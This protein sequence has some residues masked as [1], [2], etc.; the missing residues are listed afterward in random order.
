MNKSKDTSELRLVV[1]DDVEPP[2]PT[3]DDGLPQQP[4]S[5]GPAMSRRAKRIVWTF[6][7][8]II[9]I[10]AVV[11]LIGAVTS[12]P[13]SAIPTGHILYLDADQPS[14]RT[15]MLRGLYDVGN[16]GR[17]ELLLHENEPQDVDAG[18]REWIS[19]PSASPDGRH[20]AFVKQLITILDERQS[21]DY[22]IWVADVSP[23]H[24]NGGRMLIDLTPVKFSAPTRL[25][26]TSDST[27][28][29]FLDGDMLRT[30]PIRPQP[31]AEPA[32][33]I[34]EIALTSTQTLV[35]EGG[36][37]NTR[38]ISNSA[39]VA[40]R[41]NGQND[42]ETSSGGN[43]IWNGNQ[44]SGVD[45]CAVSPGGTR[46]ALTERIARSDIVVLGIDGSR[47]TIPATS[48]WSVFGY[49]RVTSLRWSPDGRYI[50]YTVSKPPVA[51]DELFFVDVNTGKAHKLPYRCGAAA[52]D[53]T[54]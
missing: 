40:I 6:A 45:V 53:W 21:D 38:G 15:T 17:Q 41:P 37:G 10:P 19:E 39:L 44:M 43:L 25:A 34:P 18:A 30:L 46:I 23:S 42:S 20:V 24:P 7:A 33:A 3:D 31:T 9:G 28:V 13:L 49:R 54:R 26:W 14:E 4:A 2:V 32:A 35:P 16:D 29:A 5:P 1:T 27:A 52:W 50:G 11:T 47:R 22:Q 36:N 51:E 48:G 12:P 8:V